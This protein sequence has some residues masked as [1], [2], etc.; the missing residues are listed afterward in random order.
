MKPFYFK[1]VAAVFAG[2]TLTNAQLNINPSVVTFRSAATA[3]NTTTHYGDL[4]LDGGTSGMVWGW[5]YANRV[6]CNGSGYFNTDL[7]VSGPMNV[8]NNVYVAGNLDVAGV[9]HFIEPHPTDTTLVIQY[10]SIEAGEVLTLA[11]GVSKTMNGAATI[12]LPEDFAMVTSSVAPI[13]VLLTPEGA[14]CL[15]FV[16]S[17]SKKSVNVEIKGV[18]FREYGDVEFSYQV[19][20]VRDGFENEKPIVKLDSAL[21]PP[22]NTAKTSVSPLEKRREE[23]RDRIRRHGKNPNK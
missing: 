11:R 16:K 23:F 15:L 21:S 3:A 20:G 8:Y 19:T 4:K 22:T 2:L 5:L 6:E 18:D 12:T 7:G 10:V 1:V 17:K 14:P 9:K 13:S